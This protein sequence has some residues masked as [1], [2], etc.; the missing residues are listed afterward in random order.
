[1]S[2]LREMRGKGSVMRGS[3]V[4]ISVVKCSWVKC[5]E[6]LQCSVGLRNKVSNIIRRH[7]DNMGLLFIHIFYYLILSH[8]MYIWLCTVINVFLLLR[9][10]VRLYTYCIFM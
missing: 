10:I 2:G 4:S 9:L 3:E 8:L 6:V 1:V 5:S 7:T